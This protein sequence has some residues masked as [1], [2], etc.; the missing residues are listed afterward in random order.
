MAQKGVVPREV[1]RQ[2][3]WGP[4][5][6]FIGIDKNAVLKTYIPEGKKKSL[7]YLE[8]MKAVEGGFIPLYVFGEGD[9]EM[10]RGKKV[11]AEVELR[12]KRERG[13]KIHYL[14]AEI[15][16]PDA[17]RPQVKLYVGSGKDENIVLL[18][19]YPRLKGAEELRRFIIGFISTTK[20]AA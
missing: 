9:L 3:V 15:L 20:K 6:A 7:Q 2:T 17:A 19:N 1:Q 12:T 5:A 10:I 14:R 16:P 13:Q 8:C 11:P 18:D 4:E